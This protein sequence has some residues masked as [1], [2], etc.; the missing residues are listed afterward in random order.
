MLMLPLCKK[1]ENCFFLKKDRYKTGKK[2]A[3]LRGEYGCFLT[4][5]SRRRNYMN[6]SGKNNSFLCAVAICGVFCIAAFA[7]VETPL[8]FALLEK[9]RIEAAAKAKQT[10]EIS[11]TNG[12]NGQITPDTKTFK[13]GANASFI[14]T[15]SEGYVID[16]ITVDEE[17]VDL[18]H[19]KNRTKPYRYT[20][21]KISASHSIDAVFKANIRV[22][23]PLAVFYSGTEY[24]FSVTDYRGKKLTRVKTAWSSDDQSVAS[25]SVSGLVTTKGE[26][27]ATINGVY[28]Q[29]P[30][31]PARIKVVNYSQRPVELE[32]VNPVEN[33]IVNPKVC[34]CEISPCPAESC[35][36]TAIAAVFRFQDG[37]GLDSFQLFLDG[38][39]VTADS[40]ILTSEYALEGGGS[41]IESTVVYRGNYEAITEGFHNASIK[42]TSHADKEV[43]YS[44]SFGL[45]R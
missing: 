11:V 24:M 35:R 1:I 26:G 31:E 6:L 37:A 23:P 34:Q 25:V 15:P 7:F 14:V 16:A 8:T 20:F 44:W 13:K 43:S 45:I 30:V 32:E 27:T 4:R 28:K 10:Y 40:M 38:T 12:A 5:L 19:V 42:G 22:S 18:S 21:K 33:L 2:A 3:K 36:S 29:A 17:D 39:D 9:P 41:G